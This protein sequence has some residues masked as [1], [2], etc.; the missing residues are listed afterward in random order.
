MSL[1][2]SD[3]WIGH[4]AITIGTT[5]PALRLLLSILVGYPLAIVHR[6][7]LFHKSPSLQHIFF[8]LCGLTLGYF[9]YGLE[10]L[11]SVIC[12]VILYLNLLFIGGTVLSVIFSISFFMGY[13]LIGY[14]YTGTQD[15]DIKWTIPHC[16]LTLRLIGVS[17]DVYDG[18]KRVEKLSEDQKKTALVKAPSL[19]EI[20]GH[21]YFFGGFLVGPQ[22]SMR[23]YM[24]FV[25]GVFVDK[26][27]QKPA[28]ILPALSRLALGLII[29]GVFQIGTLFI[30][31]QYILTISFEQEV[32][33]KKML[34]MTLWGKIVLYKYVACWLLS[35]GSCTMTG[36]TY[37]GQDKNG[38]DLWDGCCNVKIWD[39]ETTCTFD[40]L[41][42]SFNINTNHWVARYIFKRL[43]FLGN[44][45][46]S[47]AVTLLFLAMWHGLHSGYYVCFFNEFLVMKV[48]RDVTSLTDR[49][50]AVK[51]FLNLSSLQL[52]IYILKKFYL[53]FG[54]SYCVMPFVLLSASR[55][56]KV[57]SSL[58]FVCH[59]IY[60]GWHVT[61]FVMKKMKLV[62]RLN[63]DIA[64]NE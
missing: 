37:N 28:C 14:Y 4:L 36:L 18:R 19:L 22:F 56:L 16:V 11:H 48:E 49:L 7:F 57:Y 41:I 59:I 64:K 61:Y 34:I 1:E 55:W 58:Y 39:Y 62:P 25:G 45:L 27:G 32:F 38:I 35:E 51:A 33:W 12:V 54:M 17:Y 10:V 43:R 60:I 15:Y 30:P 24:D 26:K 13:L 53:L 44:K 20:G 50:P 3:S 23:R 21:T 47:Q 5:E 46:L 52:P 40:G 8:L 29:L 2:A 42:Q 63:P 6:Q 9:N 31:E